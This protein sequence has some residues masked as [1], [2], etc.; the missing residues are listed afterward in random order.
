MIHSFWQ[1]KWYLYIFYM[2]KEYTLVGIFYAPMIFKEHCICHIKFILTHN[3]FK[4]NSNHFLQVRDTVM[5]TKM[6]PSYMNI[7]MY[8]LEKI[9]CIYRLEPLLCHRYRQ[10]LHVDKWEEHLTISD[11]TSIIFTAPSNSQWNIEQPIPF[12]DVQVYLNKQPRLHITT[13]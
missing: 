5:G 13:H 10:Y 1:W 2:R 8:A 6:A 7:F 3:N 12:L 4:F 9:F 11:N